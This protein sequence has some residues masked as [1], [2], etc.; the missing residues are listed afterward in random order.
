MEGAIT[1]VPQ[2]AANVYDLKGSIIVPPGYALL[3]YH[4]IGGTASL[5]F[6]FVWE[7]VDV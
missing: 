3:T 1:T 5:I 2:T 4:S 6:H 7:E